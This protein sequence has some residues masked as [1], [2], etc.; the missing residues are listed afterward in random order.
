[1][2]EAVG[3]EQG[4]EVGV[5]G[6]GAGLGGVIDEGGEEEVEPAVLDAEGDQ[7]GGEIAILEGV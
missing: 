1:L 7:G 6:E 3:E 5:V 2:D 4:V